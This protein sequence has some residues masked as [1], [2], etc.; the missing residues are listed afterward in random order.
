MS[1]WLNQE[2]DELGDARVALILD[3]DEFTRERIE[4]IEEGIAADLGLDPH[5]VAIY[6]DARTNPTYRTPGRPIGPKDIMIQRG[7][8]EPLLMERESE[9]FREGAAPDLSW[10][11]LYTPCLNP[12]KPADT[13]LDEKAKDLLW[14]ALKDL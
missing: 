14:Q 1:I 10:I 9:I 8:N 13:T 7:E 4:T 5:L 6:L 11:H 2:I 12:H 3:P